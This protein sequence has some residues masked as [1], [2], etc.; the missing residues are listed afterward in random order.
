MY[1]YYR[2]TWWA[3]NEA[4]VAI[5][6]R[7]VFNQRGQ[8]QFTRETWHVTGF[9]QSTGQAALTAALAAR[10]TALGTN[11]GDIGLYLD[12]QAT[13]TN[14]YM[15]SGNA[16]GGTRVTAYDFPNGAGAEYNDGNPNYRTYT[17]SIEADFA[18][19]SVF[20]IDFQ[21]SLRFDGNGG[22]LKLFLPV[23][24]GPPQ[25]QQTTQQTTYRA[26]QTGHATAYGAYPTIPGPIWPSAELGYLRSIVPVSPTLQA[27]KIDQFTISWTYVFESASALFATP[28][29]L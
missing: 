4:T 26:V 15:V 6:K 20:L 23:L 24:E 5:T 7:P 29:I 8:R 16:I 17:F 22:P 19:T 2:G 11:G 9:L 28:N 27:G 13:L 21:E 18:D 14:H 3:N 10:Q 1:L 12:D 25:E